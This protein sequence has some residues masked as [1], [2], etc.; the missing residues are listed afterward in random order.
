V[1]ELVI[2]VPFIVALSRAVVQSKTAGRVAPRRIAAR[3]A[4]ERLPKNQ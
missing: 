4:L 3:G 1:V 2:G